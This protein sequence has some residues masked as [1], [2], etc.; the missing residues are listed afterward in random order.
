MTPVRIQACSGSV[1]APVRA[2]K[3]RQSQAKQSSS[4]RLEPA[5]KR[6]GLEGD[7]RRKELAELL[8]CRAETRKIP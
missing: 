1:S 4:T 2:K 5:R 3:A 7:A 6:D 8:E